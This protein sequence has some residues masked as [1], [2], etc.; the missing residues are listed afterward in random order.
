MMHKNKVGI[1]GAGSFGVAIANLMALKTDVMLFSRNKNTVEDMNSTRRGFGQSLAGR[2]N[3]TNDLEEL[4]SQCRL[5]F[6]MVP[7]SAFREMMRNMA[8]YLLP[9]H[10]IIHGTKGFDVY[11]QCE[12]VTRNE[13][14]T[15][16]EVIQQES[17]VVRIGCLSGPNLA[18]EI[19]NGQPTATVIGSKFKEVIDAGK[20]V[21]QSPLF[22]V[23]GTHDILGAEIAGAL[24]N[25]IAIGSG[26]L[27]A[28]GIG[29][30]LQAMLITRG[31][32]EMIYFGKAMGAT[33]PA[34]L[35]TAGIGDLIA[36]ATSSD[37]RN[38]SFGYEL[39]KGKNKQQIS[40]EMPELAEGVNTLQVIHQL[41]KYYRLKTPI[42]DVIYKI[43]FEDFEIETAIRYLITFPYDIDVDFL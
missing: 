1:I 20:A 36:T 12:V 17:C 7:S 37:S 15:M 3:L 5:L 31:L 22:H 38:F 10:F 28:K 32:T 33:V 13:V 23:F 26:I 25:I 41:G 9:D 6:P 16:S 8:P 29:R 19:M 35:G 14:H 4:L 27:E 21:L 34:F 40:S 18:V 39:G 30:N 43:V 11:P 42:F 2:I 24:K